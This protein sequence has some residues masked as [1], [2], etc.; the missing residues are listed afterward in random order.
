MTT[1]TPI[2]LKIDTKLLVELD[3]ET[4]LGWTKRNRHIN[5]AIRLYLSYKDTF[6]KIGSY[7][8][9]SDKR[10]ELQD[11]IKEWFPNMPG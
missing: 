1:Q 4:A 3:R 2:S 10:Q 7:G 11:F 8:N 5:R 6:R 9:L